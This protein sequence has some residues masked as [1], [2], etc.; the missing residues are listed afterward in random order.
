MSMSGAPNMSYRQPF[1]SY[2]V[3]DRVLYRNRA[4]TIIDI[5]ASKEGRQLLVRVKDAGGIESSY[6][7]DFDEVRP[8]NALDHVVRKVEESDKM[9]EELTEVRMADP[10]VGDMFT[11]MFAFWLII[12]EIYPDGRIRTDHSGKYIDEQSTFEWKPYEYASASALR[13]AFA[14]GSI[15]GY[16]VR[17]A[18]NL[19]MDKKGSASSPSSEA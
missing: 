5:A 15:P 19:L 1:T 11:E 2:A 9:S 10:R 18:R 8:F 12:R 7:T 3:G 16:T 4:A 6:E 17:Y 14:Y 13:K